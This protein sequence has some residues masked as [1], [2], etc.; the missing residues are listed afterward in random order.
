MQL[1]KIFCILKKLED[2][3]RNTLKLFHCTATLI[4]QIFG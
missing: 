3:A 1:K 2:N 4:Y